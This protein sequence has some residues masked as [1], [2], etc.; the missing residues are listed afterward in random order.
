MVDEASNPALAVD[1]MAARA[2]ASTRPRVPA[3]RTAAGGRAG[4]GAGTP[5]LA[6]DMMAARAAASTRPR[7]PAG[8][9]SAATRA[10][11]LSEFGRL[12]I[13]TRAAGP[14]RAPARPDRRQEGAAAQ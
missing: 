14:I 2:A 8:R 12:G 10:K 6:V 11:A 13:R 1:M 5:A 3:G 9:T 7:M 4:G